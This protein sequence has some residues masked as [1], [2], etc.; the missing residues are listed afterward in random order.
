MGSKLMNEIMNNLS[1]LKKIFPSWINERMIF[2]NCAITFSIVLNNV[3]NLLQKQIRQ[4]LHNEGYSDFQEKSEDLNYTIVFQNNGFKQKENF[5][6]EIN[7][8][9]P[10]QHKNKLDDTSKLLSDNDKEY[11]LNMIRELNENQKKNEEKI[12]QLNTNI[13]QLIENKKKNEEKINQL[14]TNISQL[15]ENKKKNEEKINQLNT[16][17]SKKQKN[18]DNLSKELNNTKLEN[19]H[20][21]KIIMEDSIKYYEEN[22]Q[23]KSKQLKESEKVNEKK[24]NIINKLENQIFHLENQMKKNKEVFIHREDIEVNF[25]E[26]KVF[27]EKLKKII[28]K[29]EKLP[30]ILCMLGVPQEVLE[31][32]LCDYIMEN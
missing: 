28:F 17:I 7:N 10:L 26:K 3:D 32:N 29:E 21:K 11:Y 9:F 16:N 12:N 4:F 14:N 27:S 25:I 18:I 24:V 8:I 23:L 6:T 1:N 22:L 13:S 5:I 31:E 2:I 30:L 20:E 19:D 15:I